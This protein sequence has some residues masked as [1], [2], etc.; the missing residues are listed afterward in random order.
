MTQRVLFYKL[1]KNRLFLFLLSLVG[2]VFLV[3]LYAPF[4]ASSRPFL[5]YYQ[6]KWYFPFFRCLIYPHIYTK[7]LDIFFNLMMISLPLA[8]C[9][10][11][12][13]RTKKKYWYLALLIGQLSA[14]TYFNTHTTLG[15][16][17]AIF[18]EINHEIK[19]YQ[20]NK[21]LDLKFYLSPP[22]HYHWEQNA[23]V[24]GLGLS[25]NNYLRVNGQHL[26]ATLLFGIRYSFTLA[27]L[28]CF[29]AFIIGILIGAMSGFLG[30]SIDLFICR[31]I[32][33]WESLPTLLIL[34]ILVSL[35]QKSNFLFVASIIALFSWTSIAR[36]VRLD[37]LKNRHL[38][39]IEVLKVMGVSKK[40]IL[41]RHLLPNCYWMLLSL[42]PH[43]LVG[44]ITY[45][46]ALSFLGLGDRNSCSLGLLIDEARMAYPMDFSLF[47][48]PA[49]L[50]IT[51]LITLAWLGDSVRLALD[52][53]LNEN[54]F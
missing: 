6:G 37:M 20:Q 13:V 8:C 11:K 4:F 29:L 9:I 19:A 45:E 47:W 51:T 42:F 53:R 10:Y 31:F 21:S 2:L 54:S 35:T 17:A 1:K 43:A 33:I 28:A 30:G 27:F 36:V 25:Q 18:Q 38:A 34:L 49:L 26:F 32:E 15:K 41:F 12:W 22:I 23:L 40:R 46:S 16:N 7:S 50:L 24:A 52:P 48:P 5:A 44:A 39:Y 3:G 14:F